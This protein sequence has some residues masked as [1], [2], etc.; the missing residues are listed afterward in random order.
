MSGLDFRDNILWVNPSEVGGGKGIR[1][2]EPAQ[3]PNGMVAANRSEKILLDG[4]ALRIPSTSYDFRGN[5]IVAGPGV[6]MNDLRSGYPNASANRFVQQQNPESDP[7]GFEQFPNNLRVNTASTFKGIA[8][9]GTDPGADIDELGRRAGQIR[10]QW[11]E[12]VES[13]KL[14]IVFYPPDEEYPCLA[15][16]SEDSMITNPIRVRDT[17]Q[18]E[19]RVVTVSG[20]MA[21][22]RYF[23]RISC[24]SSSASNSFETPGVGQ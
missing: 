7:V 1:W 3:L 8:S 5:L 24:A 11:I 17:S 10:A 15:E 13:N 14:D 20:L 4:M 19:R 9:D 21:R 12:N 18:G 23:Y 6:R 16:V 2:S 22:K